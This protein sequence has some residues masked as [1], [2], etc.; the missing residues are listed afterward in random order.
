MDVSTR[1]LGLTAEEYEAEQIKAITTKL[2]QLADMQAQLT[3]INMQFDDLR[4][5]ILTPE[6]LAQLEAI[7]AERKTA[8]EAA[9][10]GIDQLTAEIKEATKT[11]GATVKGSHLQAV[12]SKPRVTWDSQK[13]DGFSVAHPEIL[14]FRKV[15]EPSVSI[16]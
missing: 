12:W 16:K 3:V 6:L 13:L 5:Q 2:D 8:S 7:E 1:P 10:A 9:Q 15:G 14:A 4:K 11:Y